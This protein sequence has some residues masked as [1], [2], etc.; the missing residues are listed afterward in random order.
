MEQMVW[1]MLNWKQ[2]RKGKKRVEEIFEKI[3][4]ENFPKTMTDITPWTQEGQITSGRIS[5]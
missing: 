2:S 3:M 1:Y 4:V 5:K